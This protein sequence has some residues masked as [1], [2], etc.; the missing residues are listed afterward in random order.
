VIQKL[1]S[2][3][4]FAIFFFFKQSSIKHRL[5]EYATF[6]GEFLLSANTVNESGYVAEFVNRVESL[7]LRTLGKK[8]PRNIEYKKIPHDIED[9]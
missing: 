4:T 9:S 2:Y 5:F 1:R 8:S 6:R 7:G 3:Q